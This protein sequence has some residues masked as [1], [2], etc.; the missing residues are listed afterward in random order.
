MRSVRSPI[1]NRHVAVRNARTSTVCA[2]RLE[3]PEQ[4]ILL[5]RVVVP[6][7]DHQTRRIGHR[8]APQHE[9]M[10]DAE[11]RGVRADAERERRDDDDGVGRTRDQRSHRELQLLTQ[12]IHD[13]SPRCVA[14]RGWR[15]AH[16]VSDRDGDAPAREI[17]VVPAEDPQTTTTLRSG[18]RGSSRLPARAAALDAT[19]SR[20]AR[21]GVM[22]DP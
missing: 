22:T 15:A 3:M 9:R 18:R 13:V 7:D 5:A 20:R 16:G 17:V 14:W 10:Q 11:D 1:P 12:G 4:R 19:A 21:G 8:Q 2:V 6:Q